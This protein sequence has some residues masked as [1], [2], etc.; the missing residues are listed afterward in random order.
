[1]TNRKELKRRAIIEASLKLFSGQWDF[2]KTYNFQD[3][4]PGKA[5][6]D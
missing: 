6:K 4:C 3:I 2:T 1:V 5:L